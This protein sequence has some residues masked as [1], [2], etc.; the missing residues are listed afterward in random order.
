MSRICVKNIGL[1]S[2][3]KQLKDL[4]GTKG[5]VTDVR[6][7]RTK[8]GKS[9]QLAFIGFR[10]DVQA[11]EAIRYFNKTFIET[12]RVTVEEAKKIGDTELLENAR[13]RHTKK[14]L[15]KQA[16]TQ[17]KEKDKVAQQLVAAAVSKAKAAVP[18]KG[19]KNAVSTDTSGT[20]MSKEKRDFM[21]VMKHK[22]D[23]NFWAN[24][25]SLQ[26]TEA[27]M[28]IVEDEE[29]SPNEGNDDESDGN[30]ESDDDD[31]INDLSHRSSAKGTHKPTAKAKTATAA[32]TV[33]SKGKKA[34]A[35]VKSNGQ[36]NSDM[37]YLRSKVRAHF[38]DSDSD[39][40]KE[41]EEDKEDNSGDE[42]IEEEE[43]E[44]EEDIE[45]EDDNNN[46][47]DED[48]SKEKA[49]S[50]D[51]EANIDDDDTGRLFVRNLI[52]SCAEEELRALFEPFGPLASIHLPLDIEKKGKGF[53]FVQYVI[54]EHATRARLV[55]DGSS[56][57][58]R[59]LHVMPAKKAPEPPPE[60]ALKNK[61]KGGRLS[62][63]QQKKE[64]ERRAQVSTN[65]ILLSPHDLR[66]EQVKSSLLHVFP[67]FY[68]P[69]T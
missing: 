52:F 22:K 63:F 32:A 18:A 26:S 23:K 59:L 38:S 37:D 61:D 64:D 39:E 30:V 15:E 34:T 13:S 53:G 2:T 48:K 45:E 6:I 35:I 21:E 58:G 10:T 50:D 56:F 8:S 36:G 57:Q 44:E 60:D 3:E 4:F 65:N 62:S 55:L 42:K 46:E 14:K 51:D 54:P 68:I 47:G 25:E 9:R 20:V 49:N 40:D 67:C 33:S 16:K 11:Q 28:D 12:S 69:L 5:E 1:K 17:E 29:E 27:M 19:T 7:V 66:T 24:D 31:D 43:D 41:E